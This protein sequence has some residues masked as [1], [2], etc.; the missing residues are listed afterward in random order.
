VMVNTCVA[1]IPSIV[2]CNHLQNL[3]IS[4][5]EVE[6]P[7]PSR[8]AQVAEDVMICIRYRDFTLRG[9]AIC[10]RRGGLGSRSLICMRR[11]ELVSQGP[12]EGLM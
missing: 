11:G 10:M 3:C 12:Y 1:T 4:P 9:L 8:F 2:W 5:R 7:V 6:V